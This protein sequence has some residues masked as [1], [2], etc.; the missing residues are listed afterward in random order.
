MIRNVWLPPDKP[1]TAA[2]GAGVLTLASYAG[3][4]LD[5]RDLKAR[6]REHYRALLDRHIL[7]T[8]LARLPLKSI[9]ADDVRAW[10]AALDRST[11]TLRSHCYWLL[12]TIFGTAVTEEL[13]DA[14]PCGIVGAGR[15]SGSHDPARERGRAGRADRRDAR[16]AGDGDAG[17]MVCAAVRRGRS[18]AV[19]TST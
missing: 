10:H 8:K 4:W 13:I 12:R 5:Q 14:N 18:C 19:V 16:A 17:V 1:G 3:L 6:T 15:P 9:T 11:P 2:P 7:P